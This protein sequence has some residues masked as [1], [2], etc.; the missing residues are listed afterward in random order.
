M[1][2]YLYLCCLG[3]LMLGFAGCEEFVD[4]NLDFS[5]SRPSFIR[6]SSASDAEVSVAPGS[7]FEVELEIRETVY[8]E[9]TV[10]YTISGDYQTTGTLTFPSGGYQ[11]TYEIAVPANA[12]PAG[13]TMAVSTMTLT[14]ATGGIT[15]GRGIAGIDELTREVTIK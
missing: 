5:D 12:I 14:E 6:F 3:V 13:D 11:E 15:V 9:I 7:S 10:S 1:K 2:K 4:E 8:Q